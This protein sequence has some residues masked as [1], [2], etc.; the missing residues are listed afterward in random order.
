M[1]YEILTK[2]RDELNQ[3][4]ETPNPNQQKIT[5]NPNMLI[6]ADCKKTIPEVVA[7]YSYTWYGKYL[8]RDCQLKHKKKGESP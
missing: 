3:L 7:D 5:N 2:L 8:C 1:K 6:C 4:L